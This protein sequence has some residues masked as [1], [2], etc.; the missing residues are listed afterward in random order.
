MSTRSGTLTRAIAI[1][2]L[3][4]VLT[5]NIHTDVALDKLFASQPTLRPLDK[6]FIYEMVFGSLRWLAKMDWIMSHMI[7]RPF[8][9]LD[10]R[11]ANALRVGTYQIYYMDRVPERAAVSET[12]EAIKQVGVPN[13][14]SLVNAILR[15]VARK[16]EYFPKPDKVKQAVEYYSMHHS[17]P[18]WMVERWYNQLSLERFE[19][20]LSNSNRIPKNT[21]KIIKRNPL[22]E[23]EKDLATYLLKTHSIESTWRPLPGSLRIES[24]PK[25]DKCE[26]F[27][28]GCYIVQ[29][30]AAQLAAS[31][32][33]ISP[34]DTCLDA[35]AAPGGKSI[36]LWDSGLEPENLTVCDF[37]QKRLKILR[38]NFERVKLNNVCILHGDVVEQVKGNKFKKILLDAPCSAMGVI[39]RHPEIKWLRS[40]NDIQNCALEQ[41]RLLNSLAENVEVNGELIYVVCSF[42]SE[43]T[44]EQINN[45]LNQHPEFEKINPYDRIHDFYKK[46]VTREGE[47]LIYSGNPDDIDGF[48]AVILRKTK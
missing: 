31:L 30:E 2:A 48:F 15:R 5:R 4:H 36:Y 27:K 42:E 41:S 40:P 18:A 13:A 20:L 37:A 33:D 39:R 45:F 29:D 24:L 34:T 8:S 10:P 26:A 25:F 9:S 12:V 1:D 38:E 7:D 22:P 3:T 17:F 44:T 47:L 46:Y 21:L 19:H 16:S 23:D 14:A 43:E 32:V 28:S 35:C 11:V 6:A